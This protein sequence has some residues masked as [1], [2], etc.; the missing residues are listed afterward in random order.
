MPL[1]EFRTSKSTIKKDLRF[2]NV[3]VALIES[4]ST[5]KPQVPIPQRQTL[6]FTQT[7]PALIP[8]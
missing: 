6:R 8:T 1:L 7:E 5:V 2:I 4:C 3:A